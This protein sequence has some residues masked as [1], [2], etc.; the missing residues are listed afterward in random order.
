MSSRTFRGKL[1]GSQVSVLKYHLFQIYTIRPITHLGAVGNSCYN[2]FSTKYVNN[3]ITVLT[4]ID[5][6]AHSLNVEILVS[7]IKRTKSKEIKAQRVV[8]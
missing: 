3:L 1:F 5:S 2:F 4:P 6:K 8:N 7:A